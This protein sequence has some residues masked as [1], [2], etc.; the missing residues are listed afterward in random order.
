[1]YMW[2]SIAH[3]AFSGGRGDPPYDKALCGPL[4]VGSA[5]APTW[6]MAHK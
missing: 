3:G 5:T 1:M 4:N 6:T 2:C